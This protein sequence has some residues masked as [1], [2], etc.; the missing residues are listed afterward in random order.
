MDATTG[1]RVAERPAKPMLEETALNAPAMI[2]E[3]ARIRSTP[4]SGPRDKPI[5]AILLDAGLIKLDD[6][7]PILAAA[8]ERN[9]RFGDAAVALGLVKER[10]LRGVLAFQFDYPVLAVGSSAVSRELVAAYGLDHGVLG[11]LRALR[12]QILLRWLT[13]ED[14][15]NRVVA[16]MSPGNGE[17]RTFIAANLAV[18]FSQM[19]QRTLLIDADIRRG[20]IHSLFG[21]TNQQGL[22]ALLAD[23]HT[24]NTLHRI[25]G[26]RDLSVITKGAEPP[27]P[28]D[29]LSRES[30]HEMLDGFARTY[31]VIIVDTPPA[32]D[33]PEASI[34][35][36]RAGGVVLVARRNHTD[37]NLLS[38]LASE[39]LASGAT[40]IGSVLS[41]V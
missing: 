1:D 28:Q 16:V 27:N 17:G 30:L 19:G 32:M 4:V 13:A 29:L 11:D 40:V 33:S 7:G 14:R 31:D 23:R 39:V 37:A 2:G 21:L 35:A 8:Q 12:N 25:E 22:S 24:P 5:G 18:T 41:R 6:V 26:L 15:K 3:L 34:L 38:A 10:D 20:R 36:A 9:L